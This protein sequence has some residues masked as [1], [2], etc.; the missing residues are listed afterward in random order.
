[1]WFAT[2][3]GLT[4]GCASDEEDATSSRKSVAA[5]RV[6]GD[7]LHRDGLHFCVLLQAIFSPENRQQETVTM[8]LVF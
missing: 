3:D 1:M 6:L 5:L 8:L 7:H 4:R 2:V